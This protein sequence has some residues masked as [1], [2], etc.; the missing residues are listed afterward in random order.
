MNCWGGRIFWKFSNLPTRVRGAKRRGLPW[1][2][3]KWYRS[4]FLRHIVHKWC[5]CGRRGFIF[6]Y[7]LPTRQ[8]APSN[9]TQIFYVFRPTSR[10][11]FRPPLGL[12]PLGLPPPDSDHA[13]CERDEYV[14]LGA[15][16][17]MDIGWKVTM[18]F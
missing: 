6:R 4:V 12:S 11:R 8:G 18:T 16:V 10:A 5:E 3:G 2:T 13:K 17:R 15:Q 7:L 14:A 1:K 9:M